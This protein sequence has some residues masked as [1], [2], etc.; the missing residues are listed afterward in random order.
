MVD[1]A[2]GFLDPLMNDYLHNVAWQAH[3]PRRCYHEAR[4]LTQVGTWLGFHAYA[5]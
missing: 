1:D 5:W 3:P 2:D 4:E